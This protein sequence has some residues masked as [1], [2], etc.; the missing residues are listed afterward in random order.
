MEFSPLS[1]E[2]NLQ[3]TDAKV[4]MQEIKL[5]LLLY[6]AD[7]LLVMEFMQSGKENGEE[8][9]IRFRAD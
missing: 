4:I 8:Y 1:A 9:D 3:T 2:Q 7:Q 5:A 6:L